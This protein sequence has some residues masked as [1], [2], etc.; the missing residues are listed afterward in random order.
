MG[1]GGADDGES[2]PGAFEVAL[3][4]LEPVDVDRAEETPGEGRGG[5]ERGVML[6]TSQFH[7][8]L[9]CYLS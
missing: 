4:D 2:A 9:T 5:V 8:P 1:G 3:F 6:L 7:D